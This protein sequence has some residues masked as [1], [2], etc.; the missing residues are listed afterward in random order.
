MIQS[1]HDIQAAL[2]IL[3]EV[4]DLLAK[5]DELDGFE[6]GAALT[7]YEVKA[8]E[9]KNDISPPFPFNLM[10]KTS[11]GPKGDAIGYL[12]PETAQ[13]IFVNFRCA[14]QD[15]ILSHLS[16][17]YESDAELVSCGRMS[18]HIIA[19]VRSGLHRCSKVLRCRP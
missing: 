4:E 19:H 5:I 18:S 6:L 2:L 7:K 9:T 17:T 11:I 3:Q 13:G 16:G 15:S 12:R 8:P 10:F 1:P 14:H